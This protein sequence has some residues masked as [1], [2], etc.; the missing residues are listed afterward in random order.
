[1]VISAP[2]QCIDLGVSTRVS[3]LSSSSVV[4][5]VRWHGKLAPFWRLVAI[6]CALVGVRYGWMSL[7]NGSCSAGAVAA[8][9]ADVALIGVSP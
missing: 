7:R 4:A 6:S 8:G 9:E 2:A 3:V 1:M 5:V